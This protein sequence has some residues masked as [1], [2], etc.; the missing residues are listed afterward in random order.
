M[1][2]IGMMG[3]GGVDWRRRRV[4][5]EGGRRGLGG[6]LLGGEVQRYMNRMV[7]NRIK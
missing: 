3:R 1:D 6:L 7:R 4:G 2:W 5:G